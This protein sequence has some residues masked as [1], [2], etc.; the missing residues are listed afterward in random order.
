M[1]RRGAIPMADE[2]KNPNENDEE[3]LVDVYTLTDEETGEES[4]F[5]LLAEADIEGAHYMAL[6]PVDA[7]QAEDEEEGGY[8]IL[9]AEE[10]DGETVLYT[11]DDDD[12]FQKVADFFDDL[13]FS[14]I[15]YDA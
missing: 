14:D 12:T 5:E 13:F 7:P 9:R 6:A 15:D 10:E 11:V 8:V 2:I 4:Q 3:E 1:P